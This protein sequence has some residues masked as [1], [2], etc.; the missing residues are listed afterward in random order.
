MDELGKRGDVLHYLSK[1]E[2]QKMKEKLH[3]VFDNWY[4]MMAEKGMDGEKVLK[5]IEE[6]A[7]ETRNNPYKPDD[8]WSKAG[9]KMQ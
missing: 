1:T 5:R 6:I 7:E 8:W 4:K 9:K 3:P 2:K